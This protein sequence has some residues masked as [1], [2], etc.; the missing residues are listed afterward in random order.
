MTTVRRVPFLAACA[1]A[2]ALLWPAVA[3]G[4]AQSDPPTVD[5]PPELDRVLRDYETA[6]RARDADGLAA[7][8]TEDGFVLS[9]GRPPA[10]GREAIRERYRGS[11]GPL[12]LRPFAFSKEGD[13]GWILGG[14]RGTESGGDGGKFTLTLR[15]ESDGRW[16]IVSDMDNGN[17]APAGP[18]PEPAPAPEGR[19]VVR[20]ERVLDGRGATLEWRDIVVEN[21]RIVEIVPAGEGRGALVYE[22]REATVLPGLIDTHVHI[23]WHFDRTGRTQSREVEETPEEAILRA[24]ENAWRTLRSGV[25]TVQ[26]IGSPEDAELRDAF[27]R[28]LLPGPRILTSLS[29]IGNPDMTP[30]AMR[31][32]V[33]ELA[34]QGADVIKIFASASIRVGG[35]P[36]LSQ[37]QLD[38]VC[39]EATAAGLRTVVHAH[40]PESAA[41]A[42]NAGCTTIEHGALLDRATLELLAANGTYYDPNIDLVLRNYFENAERFLGVGSYTAEGF[43]QM[44]A[45][46]PRALATFEEALTVPGLKVLYGTDAVAG[47]HGRNWEELAYRVRTGG[48]PAMDAIVSAT[49][50]AAESLYLDH[51]LGA[52]APGMAADLI[53]T[54]GNPADEIEAL[55]RVRFVMVRGQVVRNDPARH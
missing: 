13:T 43:E 45:A 1:L 24:A 41:R 4:L 27:D 22:L 11:G 34:S 19:T 31:E 7:L 53:A 49:S 21:G 5:L 2:C 46:V 17:G 52:I 14:Y 3:P 51:E 36:T 47:S 15:R 30:E 16:Y 38:A 37:E 44:R 6:W 9:G 50:L 39:S 20:A 25:T 28:G 32:R 10:V 26:S 23:S 18:E 48:Q 54:S 40:G 55:G 29:A 8:F 42:S 35:T 33:R 12:W